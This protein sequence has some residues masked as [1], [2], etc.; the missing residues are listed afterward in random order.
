VSRVVFSVLITAAA[1]LALFAVF[2]VGLHRRWFA[3]FRQGFFLSMVIALIGVALM[4]ASVVGAWGY[5]SAKR[6]LGQ[7]LVVEL[8]AVGEIVEK[9]VTR[10]LEETKE[11]LQNFG[12]SVAPLIERNAPAAEL[13]DRL[14]AVQAFNNRLLRIELFDRDGR[15]LVSTG[16][17]GAEQ[18]SRIATAFSLEGKPFVSDAELSKSDNRQG[19][20]LI[21]SC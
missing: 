4:S 14:R 16:R 21:C 12:E 2:V 17:A 6:I 18:A 7:D 19:R 11:G 9:Q 15:L 10:D 20:R 5:E 1:W 13:R 8:Q 3:R